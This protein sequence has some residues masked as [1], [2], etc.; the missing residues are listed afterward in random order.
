MADFLNDEANE[1]ISSQRTADSN[2]VKSTGNQQ[3]SDRSVLPQ[4]TEEEIAER[5]QLEL[6]LTESADALISK[7]QVRERKRSNEVIELLDGRRFTIGELQVISMEALPYY[8]KFPNDV[9]FYS[10]LYKLLGLDSDPHSYYKP[11]II[12][13]I[14]NEIIYSRFKQEVIPVFD[15]LNPLDSY[16]KR[17]KKNHQYLTSEGQEQL[18]MFRDQAIEV[19]N[20]SRD[21]H[22]FRVKMFER[23][24]VPFQMSLFDKN[25]SE[26]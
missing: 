3:Q 7:E 2:D 18:I 19:M 1:D 24:D 16:G 14:T 8:P 25:N 10:K 22:D 20:E 15:T 11:K 6:E 9:P 5:K 17:K 23:Y 21:Y 4:L 26:A 12:A 13:K